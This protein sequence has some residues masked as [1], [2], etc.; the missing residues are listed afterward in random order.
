MNS[1]DMLLQALRALR[2]AVPELAENKQSE[3][4]DP[5]LGICYNAAEYIECRWEEE[6]W[7]S[8]DNAGMLL[9]ELIE[10][11]PNRDPSS[12]VYPV[13][14]EDEYETGRR[15]QGLWTNPRRIELLN[16]L[17]GELE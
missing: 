13:G 9:E 6:Y 16:W 15:F 12:S 10:R 7:Q 5:G 2:D 8:I 3:R 1:S 4:F 17:I 14:G 11:W